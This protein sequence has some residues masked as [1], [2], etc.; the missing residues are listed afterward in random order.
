[1]IKKDKLLGKLDTLVKLEERLIPI[2]NKHVSSTLFFSNLK[3]DARDKIVDRM[4][5]IVFTE[6][7][8]IEMLKG[9]KD[10]ITKGKKDVY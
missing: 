7:K 10:E 6:T 1:M 5:R 3:E 2:L 8:H 9:I 4:Q